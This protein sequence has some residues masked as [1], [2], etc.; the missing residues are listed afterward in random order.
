MKEYET[1]C[2]VLPEIQG[3]KLDALNDK[4]KK[5]FSDHKVEKIERQDWG[6]RKLA[7]P[8]RNYRT[9]HY[10]VL[11]YTA[12][13]PLVTDL[14]RNLGYDE[15]VLRFLTMKMDKKTPRN[16]IVEKLSVADFD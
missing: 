16:V 5:I 9:A 10:F 3:E 12:P 7:Y 1:V 14:E 6:N 4:I 2:V 8:I 11:N 15:A 13:A